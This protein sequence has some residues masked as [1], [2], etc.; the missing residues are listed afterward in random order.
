MK[1]KEQLSTKQM[2]LNIIDQHPRGFSNTLAEIAGYFSGSNLKKVLTNE[3]KE[4][5]NFNG[6]VTLIKFL[7]K[8]NYVDVMIKYSNEINPNK[9]TARNLLEFLM[10]N[11]R[12]ESFLDL[13]EKMEECSNAESKEFA[14]MYR[15]FYKYDHTLTNDI[16]SVLK[17]ISEANVNTNEMIIFKKLLLNYCFMRKNDFVM[18]KCLMEETERIIDSIENEY[19]YKVYKVRLHEIISF[20]Q[21]NVYNDPATAR[22]YADEIIATDADEHYIA[23]ANY[24]KGYSYFFTSYD[25]AVLYLNRSLEM[26][27]YMDRKDD[28]E[29]I[30]ETLEF[31][32]I[33]WNKNE[34][35][36]VYPK[37][38]L[39]VNAK[40][41]IDY[42]INITNLNVLPEFIL[43][44]EGIKENN[45]TKLMLS[46]I[47]HVKKNNIYMA[48]LAKIE[49]LKN[50]ENSLVI[51]EM[52]SVA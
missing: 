47:K 6:F 45:N 13:L 4:F 26:Y 22:K 36:V 14:K 24:I 35:S 41:G 33:F 18:T 8:D 46:L 30:K 31:L 52:M 21:L 9:K 43:Y 38:Q 37:N 49:L 39:L 12:F 25:N 51:D 48:N 34:N 27:Y 7:W 50:G 29:D 5:D 40:N 11:R 44:V 16:D 42:Q 3:T 17:E 32:S 10:S 28:A 15:L 2:I 19:L 1:L 23:F 20:N